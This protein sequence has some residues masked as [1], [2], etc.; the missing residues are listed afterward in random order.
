MCVCV[1]VCVY[2]RQGPI[3]L[4]RIKV[5]LCKKEGVGEMKECLSPRM[6]HSPEPAGAVFRCLELHVWDLM[7]LMNHKH[8]YMIHRE[9]TMGQEG[10]VAPLD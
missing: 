10:I 2:V 7:R 6:N 3:T 9:K 1:C 8:D 5:D 4:N